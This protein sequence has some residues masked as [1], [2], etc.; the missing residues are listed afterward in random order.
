MAWVKESSL[1]EIGMGGVEAWAGKGVGKGIY[2]SLTVSSRTVYY[3]PQGKG[4]W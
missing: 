1:G 4:H 3:P 2:H